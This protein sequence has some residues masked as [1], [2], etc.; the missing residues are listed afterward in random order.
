MH[1]Q[2]HRPPL[3]ERYVRDDAKF[4]DARAQLRAYLSGSLRTFELPLAP[5]GTEFPKIAWKALLDIP[6]GATGSYGALARR[7]GHD[8]AARAVGLANA[9]NPIGIVI[10]CQRVIGADG[11]LTGCGGGVERKQ[12]FL[13]HERRCSRPSEPMQ[14]QLNS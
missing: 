14:A 8:G 10:P 11:C 5:R 6:F 12:W 7:I 3:P 4:D 2:R 1:G 9:H 13:D